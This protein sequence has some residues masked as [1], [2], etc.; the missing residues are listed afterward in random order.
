VKFVEVL[1]NNYRMLDKVVLGCRVVWS[2]R[3]KASLAYAAFVVEDPKYIWF[4]AV[5]VSKRVQIL[6]IF[7]QKRYDDFVNT[8]QKVGITRYNRLL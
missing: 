1:Y 6:T 4:S 2:G 5:L 7:V 3:G 8:T